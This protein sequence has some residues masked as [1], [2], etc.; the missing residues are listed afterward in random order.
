MLVLLEAEL[1]ASPT[2][3]A[4]PHPYEG[5]FGRDLAWQMHN[6]FQAIV[7]RYAPGER[8]RG[9]WLRHF[10][11]SENWSLSD[12]WR[13]FLL[14]KLQERAAELINAANR[15]RSYGPDA[16]VAELVEYSA[17]YLTQDAASILVL[18]A[19]DNTEM[20]P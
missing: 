19:D 4:T 7:R 17:G 6:L 10:A 18:S 9:Q 8:A 16:A 3:K 2:Q 13:G 12:Q 20:L 1:S 5:Q 14:R 15:S 11:E